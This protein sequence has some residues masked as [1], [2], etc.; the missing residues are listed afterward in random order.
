[1]RSIQTCRYRHKCGAE[2]WDEAW[3]CPCT[4]SAAFSGM[5]GKGTRNA[6]QQE[7]VLTTPDICTKEIA[8]ESVP[9]RLDESHRSQWQYFGFQWTPGM[10]IF[11]FSHC[12]NRSLET[13]VPRLHEF[14]A[15]FRNFDGSSDFR[16]N[17]WSYILNEKVSRIFR[18]I[19]RCVNHVALIWTLK[20]FWSFLVF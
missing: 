15:S 9:I 12:P 16:T 7:Q 10:A 2:C 18:T 3:H 4:T 13:L 1:M 20:Q 6:V 11:R 8:E 19:C 14:V 17:Q 5:L